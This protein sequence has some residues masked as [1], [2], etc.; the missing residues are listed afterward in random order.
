MQIALFPWL[1]LREPITLG[2]LTFLPFRDERGNVSAPLAMLAESLSTIL[3]GYVD[4]HGEPID[5]CVVVTH[6]GR[7][8]VWDLE[9]DDHKLVSRCARILALSAISRSDY[10]SNIG[11]YANSTTFQF[12]RQRFTEPVTYIAFG[13][14]RRDGS[15]TD[16][17]YRHGEIKFSVPPQSKSLRET[18]IDVDLAIAID[19]AVEANSPTARRLV[20]ALSFFNLANTDSDV[21]DMDAEVILF[22]SAFEQVL[23][24]YGAR[25]FNEAV[26]QLLQP[27]ASTTVEQA[28]LSLPGI[29][30]E[31]Q[32]EAA[33]RAWPVHRKWAQELYE[34]RNNYAH[35]LDYDS[36]MWGWAPIEHVVMAAFAFPLLVKLML[37]AEQHYRLTD[38]DDGKLAAIDKLLGTTRWAQRVPNENATF[39]QDVLFETK[40]DRS[41]SSAIAEWVEEQK[42]KEAAVD[43]PQGGSDVFWSR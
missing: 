27:Y 19:Q 15:T 28:L 33:Q 36:R 9:D 22:G 41:L 35:G 11:H 14:R 8:P 43:N 42:R 10:N 21:M 26:G 32:Y 39:W 29:V 3:R 6:S 4:M 2:R 40:R 38:D 37:S 5:N 34:L 16:A 31:A 13:V 17:G 20:P 1:F 25:R 12:F 23:D 30:I 24:A 18:S 7:N